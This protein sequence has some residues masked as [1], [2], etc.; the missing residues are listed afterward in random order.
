MLV[1]ETELRRVIGL[2][3]SSLTAIEDAFTA[4]ARGMA[5]V[6]A[7]MS[8]DVEEPPGE[9]HVKTAHIHGLDSLAIKIASGFYRNDAFKLPTASG[10]IIVLSTHTGYPIAVLADNGYLTQI[11]TALAGAISAKHLAPRNTH[12]VGIIGAGIQA[13]FQLRSLRLV[14]EFSRVL[15]F[16]RHPECTQHYATDMSNELG[17]AVM[18]AKCVSDVVEKSDLVITC[19]PSRAPLVMLEAVH[20]SLHITAVGADGPGK[21]ELDVRVL[22]RADLVVCDRKTQCMQL[23]ELQHA[24]R[25]GILNEQSDIVELGDIT[26]GV[27]LGRERHEDVTVCDLTGVGIQDTAIAVRAYGLAMEAGLGTVINLRNG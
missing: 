24:L 10:L 15:V 8:V 2:D 7:P 12:T 17:M 21:Q 4:L 5:A 16:S 26:S 3:L 11:R 23:G 25:A 9:I 20:E 27:R 6:P 1:R 22:G 18:P 19:T 13:R 14:R